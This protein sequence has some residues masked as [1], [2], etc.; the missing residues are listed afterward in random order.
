MAIEKLPAGAR[1]RVLENIEQAISDLL[2]FEAAL[3]SSAC[4]VARAV[5]MR[6]NSSTRRSLNQAGSTLLEGMQS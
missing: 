4:P 6:L 5:G 1:E 3:N 2:V